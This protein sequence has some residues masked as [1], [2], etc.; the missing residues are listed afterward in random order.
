MSVT[1]SR[2]PLTP[3]RSF[4]RGRRAYGIRSR[5]SATMELSMQCT[6]LY[7]SGSQ[8]GRGDAAP[9]GFWDGVTPRTYERKH[10]EVQ[11]SH[12]QGACQCVTREGDVITPPWGV[13]PL[14]SMGKTFWRLS[15][16]FSLEAAPQLWQHHSY[17]RLHLGRE[18]RW[19]LLSSLEQLHELSQGGVRVVTT[20]SRAHLS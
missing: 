1:I 8:G 11:T 6:L 2:P 4:R 7:V 12:P 20:N 18:R 19:I 3:S 16:L 17:S 5:S 10:S 9:C 13:H 14:H 15:V